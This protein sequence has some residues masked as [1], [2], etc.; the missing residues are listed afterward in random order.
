MNSKQ[1]KIKRHITSQ[2]R[3][4]GRA[5]TVS[6]NHPP[7]S[8]HISFERDT[9]AYLGISDHEIEQQ[10]TAISDYYKKIATELQ[11]LKFQKEFY[12]KHAR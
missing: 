4:G 3:D 11:F 12:E 8:G 6:F 2:E 10:L 7:I 9:L 5:C 1:E